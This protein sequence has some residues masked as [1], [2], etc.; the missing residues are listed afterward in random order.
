MV[1][2]KSDFLLQNFS[3][4]AQTNKKRLSK[5]KQEQEQA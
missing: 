1:I 2:E 3:F 5:V 4:L